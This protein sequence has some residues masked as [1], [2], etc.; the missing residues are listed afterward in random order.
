MARKSRSRVNANNGLKIDDNLLLIFAGFVAIV[1]ILI[2]IVNLFGINVSQF[3]Q[4]STKPLSQSS[5]YE[6]LQK[7]LQVVGKNLNDLDQSAKDI[8]IV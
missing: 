5:S 3:K 2:A 1:L 4:G 7:D 6:Q 8:N